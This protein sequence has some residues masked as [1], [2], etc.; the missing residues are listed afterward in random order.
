MTT[1]VH[2]VL[3]VLPLALAGCAAAPVS[4]SPGHA[5]AKMDVQ[6]VRA[7]GSTVA[8][9]HEHVAAADLAS[10]THQAALV[11]QRDVV[12]ATQADVERDRQAILSM[13]GEYQVSYE[14]AET[15]AMQAGYQRQEQKT[16]SGNEI[17]LVAEDA[18][19]K[20]VLQHILVT[21]DGH[22]IKHWRQ[23]WLY[24]AQAR[25]EFTGDQ[26]WQLL[27]IDVQLTQGAW[28]QCVYEVSDA[29]RYCGTGKWQ[30]EHGISTWTSDDTWRPLPR[31][32]FT[33]RHDYDVIVGVNRH[34]VVPDGWTHEQ[35]NI[36][37][38]LESGAPKGA[39]A[40]EQGFNDY[41]RVEGYDFE[42]GRKYWQATQACWAK[43]RV[44]WDRH[45]NQ[46]RGIHLRAAP[47][48][49]GL[50]KQLFEACKPTDGGTPAGDA[51]IAAILDAQ[52]TAPD[53][54]H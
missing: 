27:P 34:T 16:S 17:V 11:P 22:V 29:P 18:P 48:D 30:H 2:S 13:Q 52:V 39:I 40:R 35:D 37:T 32:E 14:F 53:K 1:P 28:T 41:R 15:V 36:K 49:M 47:D 23:D 26:T 9:K 38:I 24:E 44:H 10:R 46:T 3:M 54:S 6:S 43:V 19:G 31:R 21:K 5:D 50:I 33:S 4:P 42:P 7:A 20:V 51:A 8:E 45:I 12:Q 25:L